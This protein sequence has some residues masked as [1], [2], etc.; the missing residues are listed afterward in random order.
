M[1]FQDPTGSLNSRMTVG[2]LV[3]EPLIVHDLV[4]SSKVR[5][6]SEELLA[7]VGMPADSVTRYPHEFSGGQRQRIAIARALAPEPDLVVCDEPI[8]AL[9]V[10]VRAQVMNLLRR[11]Q[12]ERDLTYLFISHDLAAVRH[13]AHRVAVMYLGK[14]MEL[15]D[16]TSLYAMPV[17]PYTRALL[18]AVPVPDPAVERTRARLLL[19]GEVPSPLNPP[20]GCV[21]RTRCPLAQEVCALEVPEWRNIGGEREHWVA[22]HFADL[23]PVEMNAKADA[24]FMPSAGGAMLDEPEVVP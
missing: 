1:V 20:S 18:S 24:A 22:C 12:R 11:L 7:A 15:T 16:R 3:S 23:D 14:L 13:L 5:A 10:S 9:D 8:A 4:P 6:R 17:H 21:F 19:A 2:E